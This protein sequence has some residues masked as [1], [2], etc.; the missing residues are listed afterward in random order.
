MPAKEN[1]PA[2]APKKAASKGI[3]KTVT[4]AVTKAASKVVSKVIGGVKKPAP[5]KKKTTRF[6]PIIQR[7]NRNYGIGN[8]IQP[9]RDLTR[10]VRWPRYIRVQRQKKILMSRL[11]VP[12]SIHQFTRTLD[13]NNAQQLFKLLHKYRPEEK[14]AKRARL[15]QVAAAREK[16]DI[17][18]SIKRPLSVAFGAN[19]VVKAIETKSAKLVI[20]AH[21]VDPIELVVSLPTLARKM[22]IPYV[23]VKGKARL[24][25]IG[26]RKFCSAVAITDVRKEDKSELSALVTSARELF[27]DNAE[28]RRQWG[29]GK[30]GAK[31]A[32]V[33]T[34]RQKIIQKE[35]A[36]RN[37]A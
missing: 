27:N 25:V 18:E 4:K 36:A 22:D 20:I 5:P 13:S 3:V 14:K 23:I 28:H 30:L 21:D 9:R 26:Y 33:I 8:Q 29:G 7:K 17:P 15:L 34:K 37:K 2:A 12:P 11:K 1:K 35:L 6:A 10:Y 24:G 19:Q 31:S 32:A 16:G